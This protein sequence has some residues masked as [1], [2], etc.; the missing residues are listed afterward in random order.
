MTSTD[1]FFK[2]FGYQRFSSETH[3]ETLSMNSW[4]PIFEKACEFK[5][6]KNDD[7]A[8]AIL[9]NYL[10]TNISYTLWKAKGY[11]HLMSISSNKSLHYSESIKSFEK[12]LYYGIDDYTIYADLGNSFNAIIN[13]EMAEKCYSIAIELKNYIINNKLVDNT[14]VFDINFF[15]DSV[16]YEELYTSRAGAN[17]GKEDYY[18]ALKDCNIAESYDPTYVNI[19][20]VRGICYFHLNEKTLSLK[21][22]NTAITQGSTVAKQILSNLFQV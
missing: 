9:D 21:S 16:S 2:L 1:N 15:K 17:C 10:K 20:I 14:N 22:L 5:N 7:A 18:T 12:S 4:M 3:S 6:Q 13:N 19:N 8:F 11:L